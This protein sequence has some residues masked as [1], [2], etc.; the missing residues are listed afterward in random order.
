MIPTK[1]ISRIWTEEID[2]K[3][4]KE[5]YHGVA[6]KV[7]RKCTGPVQNKMK[8]LKAKRTEEALM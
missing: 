7:I 2:L 5:K 3:E 1:Y 8:I 4:K 6:Q